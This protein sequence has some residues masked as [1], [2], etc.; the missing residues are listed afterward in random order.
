MIYTIVNIR[1]RHLG[2][3]MTICIGTNIE[4]PFNNDVYAD[5]NDVIVLTIVN[6]FKLGRKNLLICFMAQWMKFNMSVRPASF[7]QY[8]HCVGQGKINVQDSWYVQLNKEY[9]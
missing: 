9:S 6:E 5:N 3:I 2:P 1:L 7:S 8:S 4:I